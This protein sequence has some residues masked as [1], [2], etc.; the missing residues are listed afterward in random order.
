[1][2]SVPKIEITDTGPV[3]PEPEVVLEAVLDDY[4]AAFGGDMSR[5]LDTPQGQMSQSQSS[6]IVDKDDV[7][8]ELIR[9]VNPDT[10][11]GVMQDAI[12]RIYLLQRIQS[13][14]T[15]ADCL[16]VG[17]PGTTIPLNSKIQSQ[18]NDIYVSTTA[19]VIPAGGS[20]TISFQA[21]DGGPLEAPAGTLNKIYV[22]ITGWD[23]VNNVA[24]AI[25]GRDEETRAEFELRRKNSV[26]LNANGSLPAIRANVLEVENVVDVFTEENDTGAT[27]VKR[28]VSLIE[29]SLY[30]C[31]KGGIDADIANAIWIRKGTGCDYNGDV[32]V[33]VVDDENYQPPYPEYDILFKRPEDVSIQFTVDV[34]STSQTPSNYEE[35]VQDAILDA[36]NNPGF[37]T[38][39]RIGA[40]LVAFDYSTAIL[41]AG[42]QPGALTG[43]IQISDIQ[44]KTSAGSFGDSIEL[45]IDEYPTLIRADITVTGP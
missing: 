43:P 11:S 22:Q 18:N 1:M 40:V 39:A 10:S 37:R 8:V 17:V 38:S 21:Q 15:V 28:G 23:T 20:I 7:V 36:F 6:I 13:R 42:A 35:L 24:D 5:Q 14:S 27:V 33:V 9:D 41:N 4:D 29:H 25:V 16:C 19:A 3:A 31:V 44:I 26:A 34:I 45:N 2:S 12:G 32:A 30:V